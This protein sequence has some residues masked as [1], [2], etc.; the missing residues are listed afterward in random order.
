M[1][2]KI[3][4]T[5]SSFHKNLTELRKMIRK[6]SK[7]KL[8]RYNA[9]S[10]EGLN[11]AAPGGPLSRKIPCGQDSQLGT[12]QSVGSISMTTTLYDNN[13]LHYNNNSSLY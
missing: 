8:G 5:T 7:E 13:N 6:A 11:N 1:S 12:H 9:D 10:A 3:K 2:L 4:S